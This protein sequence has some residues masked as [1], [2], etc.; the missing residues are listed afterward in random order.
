MDI[1]INTHNTWSKTIM[2][3]QVVESRRD[4]NRK[5]PLK[6]LKCID[7]SQV[8]SVCSALVEVASKTTATEILK[9]NPKLIV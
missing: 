9:A 1:Q 3:C 5:L 2:A 7:F 6:Q 8:F 4:R